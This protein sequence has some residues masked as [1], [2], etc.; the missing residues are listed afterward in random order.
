MSSGQNSTEDKA[1]LFMTAKLLLYA[2]LESGPN[3]RLSCQEDKTIQFTKN[4]DQTQDIMLFTF[5]T[6]AG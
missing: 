6:V 3:E 5:L 2:S 1:N 4:A